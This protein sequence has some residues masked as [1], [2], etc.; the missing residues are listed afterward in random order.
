VKIL[1]IRLKG[2]KEKKTE[3]ETQGTIPTWIAELGIPKLQPEEIKHMLY[4]LEPGFLQNYHNQ[5]RQN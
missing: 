2:K 5:N 3:E 1:L 4:F